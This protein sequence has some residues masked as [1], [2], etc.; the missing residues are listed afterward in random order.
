MPGPPPP[1]PP[2]PPPMGGPPPPPAMKL[3]GGGGGGGDSRSDLLKSIADPSKPRLRKVDP[4]MI[5][6]RSKPIVPGTS[7]D[8]SASGSAPASSAGS[9]ASEKSKSK[10]LHH[11]SN[12]LQR[13]RCSLFNVELCLFVCLLFVRRRRCSDGHDELAR[14]VEQE[15]PR[16]KQTVAVVLLVRLFDA[17]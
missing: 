11:N 6:D 13:T 12:F 7:N 16:Q 2:P 3:S 15:V 4:N 9:A 1:P 10:K 5:K 17:H 14:S 8:S